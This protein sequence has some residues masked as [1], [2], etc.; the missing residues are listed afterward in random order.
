MNARALKNRIRSKVI[1][2]R[3]ERG[4]LEKAYHHH[5]MPDE[6]SNTEEKD[7]A[8]TKALLKRGNKSIN[9]LVSKFNRLAELMCDLKRRKKAPPKARI[10]PL[11]KTQKLFRLDV[12]NDI[13]NVDGLG[14]EN[15]TAP[16]GWLA[17]QDIHNGIIALLSRSQA[18]EE[19]ERIKIEEENA[20]W[21]LRKEV[22]RVQTAILE[23]QDD[24]SLLY[25]MEGLLKDLWNLSEHWQAHLDQEGAKSFIWMT[26]K[27][28]LS[29]VAPPKVCISD[30][31]F[32]AVSMLS[33]ES[34]D[35]EPD[36]AME[37]DELGDLC[38][39]MEAWLLGS[40]QEEEGLLEDDDE[41]IASGDDDAKEE[42]RNDYIS[43]KALLGFGWGGE[44]GLQSVEDVLSPSPAVPDT[45]EVDTTPAVGLAIQELATKSS[46]SVPLLKKAKPPK[47]KP[48]RDSLGK[49]H[50]WFEGRLLTVVA[51]YFTRA[52]GD[53]VQAHHTSSLLLFYMRQILDHPGDH[54]YSETWI[55]RELDKFKLLP[56]KRYWVIPVHVPAHWTLVIIDWETNVVRYLDSMPRC[57][58]AE[59]DGEC[60][61][62]EA[63]NVL[64]LFWTGFNRDS[65]SWISEERQ[66]NSYD[67]GAFT[68]GDM[69]SFIKD[70]VVSPLTQDNMKGWRREIIGILD[71]MPGLTAMEVMSADEEP[72]DVG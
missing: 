60:V 16:P 12:D 35:D 49:R 69:V 51:E 27:D 41:S 50:G 34:S 6:G 46:T 66:R 15:D 21:W 24:P 63:W 17:N 31:P 70:G 5:V 29:G 58:G 43:N 48:A 10:P 52:I 57:L 32:D 18:E 7:H 68:L 23:A 65:W 2:Q 20:M 64:S 36:P 62:D 54:T 8:Q 42:V 9:S 45:M 38:E 37:K 55:C 61:K 44:V 56:P 28:F 53:V 22:M 40:D 71:S 11:L 39:H 3:F 25:Q 72:I 13:W 59:E 67:C 14:D 1:A 19:L 26:A 4:Q 33:S 30:R 47:P